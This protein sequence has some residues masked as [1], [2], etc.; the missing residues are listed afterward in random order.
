[1]HKI[2]RFITCL[3]FILIWVNPSLAIINQLPHN[4]AVEWPT[5]TWPE[6]LIEIDDEGFS[7]I[8]NYFLK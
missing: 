5:N 6:N 8:I 4:A 2:I 3:A 7:A 1:M